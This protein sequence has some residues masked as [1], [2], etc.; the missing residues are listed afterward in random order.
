MAVNVG[1]RRVDLSVANTDL[2]VSIPAPFFAVQSIGSPVEIRFSA[3]S[4][5]SEILGT[6]D[7]GRTYQAR[8]NRDFGTIYITNEAGSGFLLLMYSEDVCVDFPNGGGESGSAPSFERVLYQPNPINV[9]ESSPP[10]TASWAEGSGTGVIGNPNDDSN[11]L[12]VN[13][14]SGG[15]GG[16]AGYFSDILNSE[17]AAM[18]LEVLGG[19]D[20]P[21]G[22]HCTA[23]SASNQYPGFADL[24]AFL[25]HT[26]TEVVAPLRAYEY[27][28]REEVKLDY[29][30]ATTSPGGAYGFFGIAET[31]GPI[32]ALD[33]Y[34]IGF[35]S[36]GGAK[37]W[38]FVCIDDVEAGQVSEDLGANAETWNV[39]TMK[40]GREADGTRYLRAYLNDVL[41][42]EVTLPVGGEWNG[43]AWAFYRI[44]RRGN[45]NDAMTGYFMRTLGPKYI[46][47]EF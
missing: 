33:G 6:S 45:A 1:Y 32:T 7:K 36:E 27:E 17:G 15:A 12:V 20:P 44:V 25:S 29:S 16:F 2:E 22:Q 11:S 34:R 24:I 43:A 18:G 3:A 30:A 10:T 14:S 9:N 28:L 37:S 39:L 47:R 31:P 13:L 26:E 42:Y 19:G 5:N 41:A 23:Q 46:Y 35:V 38:S 21:A 8:N 4:T 40:W